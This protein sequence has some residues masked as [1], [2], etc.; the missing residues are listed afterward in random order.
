M[1]NTESTGNAIIDVIL[2]IPIGKVATYGQIAK[3]AGYRNGARLVV[4]ALNSSWQKY[5]L[6]W[7]RIVNAKGKIS[8]SSEEGRFEQIRC[9]LNEGVKVS[10]E[11][12]ID[13]QEYLW[14]PEL[15][16]NQMS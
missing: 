7:Y 3:L 6:P 13:L 4:W 12:Q 10:E 5:N 15:D 11:G 1:N 14:K 8:L 16:P 2:S 9:L